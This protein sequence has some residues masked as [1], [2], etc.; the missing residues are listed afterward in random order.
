VEVK[1]T[2]SIFR[3]EISEQDL[4]NAGILAWVEDHAAGGINCFVGT[5]RDKTQNKTVTQLHYEAYTPMALKEMQKLADTAAERW[6]I[7]KCAIVH[8]VGTLALGKTAVVIAVSCPHRAAAFEAC[9]WLIDN[10]KVTV[11]IWKKEYFLD[12]EIWVTPHA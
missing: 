6:P 4:D 7:I 8:R 10:L 9:Q 2:M 11:P 5:V 12:G 1:P 3:I